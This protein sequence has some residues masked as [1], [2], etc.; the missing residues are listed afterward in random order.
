MFLAVE[1]F[2]G[3]DGQSSEVP[4]TFGVTAVNKSG[5]E[6]SLS[7]AADKYWSG[8]VTDR[9]T[10]LK[11]GEWRYLWY[12]FAVPQGLDLESLQFRI[13]LPAI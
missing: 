6:Y 4:A 11:A 5:K 8:D 2:V 3:N 12:T 10:G 9:A 7:A 13:L 1:F